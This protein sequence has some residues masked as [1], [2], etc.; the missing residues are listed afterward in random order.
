MISNVAGFH[1]GV[2]KFGLKREAKSIP[3]L[4]L[5]PSASVA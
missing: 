1:A 2:K 5:A 4:E 3:A